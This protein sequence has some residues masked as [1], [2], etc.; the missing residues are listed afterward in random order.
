MLESRSKSSHLGRR[1]EDNM[2]LGNH[3]PKLNSEESD[4]QLGN[5][6]SNDGLVDTGRHDNDGDVH[7]INE[8]LPVDPPPVVVDPPPVYFH[9]MSDSPPPVDNED[10]EPMTFCVREYFTFAVQEA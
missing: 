1:E 10:T 3:D 9:I 2:Q 8:V 5:L 4:V 7:C 6:N